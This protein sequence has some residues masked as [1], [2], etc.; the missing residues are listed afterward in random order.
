MKRQGL[1]NH[2]LLKKPLLSARNIERRL[3]FAR[4]NLLDIDLLVSDIIWS[5][6]TTV[7]KMPKDKDLH[8]WASG[9][10]RKEDLPVVSES[11]KRS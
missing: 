5:D 8:Y 4:E 1:A 10:I 2:K 3:A 11:S 9:T 7:R 6:E